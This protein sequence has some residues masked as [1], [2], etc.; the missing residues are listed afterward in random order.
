MCRH[1]GMHTLSSMMRPRPVRL[2]ALPDAVAE[3]VDWAT[4]APKL[5]R[6]FVQVSRE[7]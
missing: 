1:L 5:P 6:A 2:E 3:A 7:T 4:H